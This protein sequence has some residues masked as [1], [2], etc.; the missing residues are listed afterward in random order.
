MSRYTVSFDVECTPQDDFIHYQPNTVNAHLVG[1]AITVVGFSDKE[2]LGMLVR[3][4]AQGMF[5]DHA[6]VIEDRARIREKTDEDS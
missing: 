2:A 3:F 5:H 1:T 6:K 4:L